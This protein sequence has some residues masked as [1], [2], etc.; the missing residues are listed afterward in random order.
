MNSMIRQRGVTAIGWVIILM[1][2]GFFALITLKLVP[3]YLNSF[4]A[5]AAMN[6]IG[7]QPA[8]GKKSKR[9][10]IQMLLRNLDIN[11]FAVFDE[12]NYKEHVTIKKLKGKKMKTLRVKY[13]GRSALFGDL[14][15]VLS[16][17]KSI[18]LPK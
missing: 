8:I 9:E 17:D 3:L 15:I 14:A 1:L 4:K 2:I 6:Y 10:V 16:Y 18:D 11:D 13:E 5:D 7:K 12:R